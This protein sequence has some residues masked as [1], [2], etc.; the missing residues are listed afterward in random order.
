MSVTSALKGHNTY[1][2]VNP[3]TG[4]TVKLVQWNVGLNFAGCGKS[5]VVSCLIRAVQVVTR[6]GY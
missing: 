3:E 6:N 4:H 5:L 2:V 1:I